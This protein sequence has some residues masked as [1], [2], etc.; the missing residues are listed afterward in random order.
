MHSFPSGKA[1]QR[2]HMLVLSAVGV[3]AAGV[4][5]GYLAALLQLTTHQWADYFL[6]IAAVTAPLVVAGHWV[7]GLSDAPI[8]ECI[9]REAAGEAQEEHYRR[10][11]Y[12][13]NRL[14]A[15]DVWW[16]TSNWLIAAVCVPAWMAWRSQGIGGFVVSVVAAAA[17]SGAVGTSLFSFHA[18]RRLTLPVR[19]A[20]A[21]RLPLEVREE[22][23]LPVS[24]NRKM[25]LPMML[26]SVVT[27][28]FSVLLAYGTAERPVEAHDVR[29]KA[30]FLS[31]MVDQTSAGSTPDFEHYRSAARSQL[32]ASDLLY[33]DREDGQFVEGSADLLQPAEVA[34]ILDAGAPSGDSQKLSSQNSFA[35][36]DLGE[37][38][39][40]VLV[41]VTPKDQLD[42][43]VGGEAAEFAGL[44]V[45]VILV[46]LAVAR[47]TSED[48]SRVTRRLRD[49][50][51]RIAAGDL[52]DG[53][54]IE[55]DDELGELARAFDRM[56]IGLRETIGKA[57][58]TA[59]GV[60]A[61]ANQMAEV[62]G[63]V[64]S[65]TV[66]QVQGIEQATA[67][68]ASLDRQVAGITGSAE[69]LNGNVEEA[70]SSV[71][72]LGAA[73]EE[74]NQTASALNSQVEE[75]SSSIEQMIRSVGQIVENSV[76]LAEAVAQTSASMSQMATSMQEVDATA[77]ETARLS[78]RVVGLAEGGQERVQKTISGMDA[79]R[80]ATDTASTVIAGLAG[81]VEEIGAIVD[82]IDDVA[83]ETNLLALNAAIIAAQAGDQG[84]AFSVVADE[85]KDLADRVLSS[86]KEIGGLI[87]AVQQE[88]GNATAAIREGSESV[89]S[90]ESLSAEAGRSLEEI[91]AAAR[92][93]GSRIEEIVASVREQVRAAGHV[94][95][96]MGRVSDRVEEI[97]GA[98][99]EQERGNEIV[100]RGSVVMRDVAQQTRCTTEEQS[101]GAMRIRESM[102]S[103]R[104]AVDRIHAALQE[105]SGA[106]RQ[107]VSFLEQV[108]ERTRSNEESTRQLGD[109]SRGLQ[110]QAEVL[111]AD[112]RR[113]RL[114]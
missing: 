52:R 72:E 109:A 93:S 42:V 73:G 85:I 76:G 12:A 32:V 60:E 55:S 102:E 51:L 50:A 104:D 108:F 16:S 101:R 78:A 92:D 44:F 7:Q 113:F 31:S 25:A 43:A 71:L 47:L 23:V 48:V 103:V 49:H 34:W 11:L 3:A 65:A 84:R 74:L 107:A 80:K 29:I 86:T 30:A 19:N 79:I 41:A 77:G 46:S 70:S 1:F 18:I 6:G 33:L 40:L 112:V 28:T 110:E 27:V 97:Q 94:N 14:A 22:L 58:K 36:T 87:H 82:V 17:I 2:R 5:T 83:D 99:R 24:L 15:R 114:G 8:A 54:A 56:A 10:G 66:D 35:W 53:E 26:I 100:M 37:E 20:W 45:L 106:C 61:A 9:D 59:D 96:L 64:S 98:S 75:V 39:G 90:G 62:A 4:V 68:M 89:Q 105:Q 91:T 95:S 67:S 88:S 13:A 63:A 38:S 69:A 111:R 57:L 81:R 21:S